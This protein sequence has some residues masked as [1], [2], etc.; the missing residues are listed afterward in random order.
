VP[1]GNAVES[2]SG[3]YTFECQHGAPECVGNMVETCV[4]HFHPDVADWW[5]FVYCLE[6]GTPGT[7]GEKCATSAGFT[8]WAEISDCTTSSL[9]NGLMHKNAL[10]TNNLVPPH[11]YTPWVT[12]D[13]SPMSESDLGKP[14]IEVV[15]GLYTG[16]APAACSSLKDT[17]M[18]CMRDSNSTQA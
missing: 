4:L 9:G 8:D 10:A 5:P 12:L 7:D 11:Q 14:L 18:K 15:C 1:F 17:A 13:G 6:N 2:G 3:P 16:A